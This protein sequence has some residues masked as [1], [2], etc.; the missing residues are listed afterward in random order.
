MITWAIMR[1]AA[2]ARHR[3]LNILLEDG[4]ADAWAVHMLIVRS[5]YGY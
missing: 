2:I 4:D 3:W 1:R 5:F